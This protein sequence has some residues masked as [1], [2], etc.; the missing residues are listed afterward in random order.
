MQDALAMT[1]VTARQLVWEDVYQAHGREL[2]IYLTRLTHDRDSAEDLLQDTFVNAMRSA[3]DLRD[4]GALRAWLYRIA[5]NS[6]FRHLRRRK[7]LQWVPLTAADAPIE[8]TFEAATVPVHQALRQISREQAAALL[9]HYQQ[10]F[11]RHE[12][13]SITGLSED[14]VKSRLARG[15]GNFIA[16]YRRLERGL[17]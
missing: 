2:L 7:L 9:L 11:S 10:G 1:K 6:A 14:G 3:A 16:A 4:Q 12:I 17:K 13:A 8:S 5:T 15:R